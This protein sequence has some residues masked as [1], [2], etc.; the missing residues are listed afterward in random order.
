MLEI[1]TRQHSV[2]VLR[3]LRSVA[4]LGPTR[5]ANCQVAGAADCNPQDTPDT[6][7]CEILGYLR[8]L[9]SNKWFLLLW[10][11]EVGGAFASR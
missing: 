3:R 2:A 9:A 5:P 6:S 7:T 4:E 11:G 8:L 1:A 10:I